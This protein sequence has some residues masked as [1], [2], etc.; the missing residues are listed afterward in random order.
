[1]NTLDTE[2]LS[3]G[4]LAAL[5]ATDQQTKLAMLAIRAG[6]ERAEAQHEADTDELTGLLSRRALFR[7]VTGRITA[8]KP[9]GVL[10]ADLTNFKRVNDTFDHEIGDQYLIA[11][12]K[13]IR[14]SLD[15]R[16]EDAVG[17]LGG[18]E[19]VAAVSLEPRRD[20]AMT[21]EQRLKVVANR[22]VETFDGKIQACRLGHLGL[23][24]AIGQVVYDPEIHQTAADILTGADQQMATVKDAQHQAL[25]AY[26]QL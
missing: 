8:G 16:S 12:G 6:V 10:F 9:F 11:A 7:N 20:Q 13:I 15:L 1:M 21:P 5:P 26:R 19:F 18:D 2:A 25:G 14:R 4:G 17:R 23:G 22:I 24:L 3:Y